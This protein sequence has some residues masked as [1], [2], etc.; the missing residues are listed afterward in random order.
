MTQIAELELFRR[1]AKDKVK[2]GRKESRGS[3]YIYICAYNGM[4]CN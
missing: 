3:G 2:F 1:E 4:I